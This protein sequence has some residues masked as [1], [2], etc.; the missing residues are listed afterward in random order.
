MREG[1]MMKK[2]YEEPKLEMILFNSL[3]YTDAVGDIGGGQT[4]TSGGTG[5][6]IEEY[7]FNK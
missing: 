3:L 6:G 7:D 1:L 4:I 5:T 2:I